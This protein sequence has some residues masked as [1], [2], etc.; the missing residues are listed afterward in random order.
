MTIIVI[1]DNMRH[2][3]TMNKP[4]LTRLL[5][6][7]EVIEILN[8]G[9]AT[10]YRMIDAGEIKAYKIGKGVRF[11]QEEIEKYINSHQ[12]EAKKSRK[13]GGV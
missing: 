8:I 9:R 11:K 6:I 7:K 10:L 5:S 1:W 3:D 12:I 4:K 13:K 2:S